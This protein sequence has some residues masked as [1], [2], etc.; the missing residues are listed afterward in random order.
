ML[1]TF[2]TAWIFIRCAYYM[3]IIC[4]YTIA[5]G[6]VGRF[7]REKADAILAW[8]ANKM[9]KVLHLTVILKNP[10]QINFKDGRRYLLMSNHTSL[11]DIPI[12]YAV[13]HETIRMVAKIELT[14]IPIF[15]RA[16]KMGEVPIVDR[17]NRKAAIESLNETQKLL[18]SGVIIWIAP[19]GTRSKTGKLLPFKKGGFIM[20]IQAQ[21]FIVPIV[22]EGAHKI[23][24]KHTW[25]FNTHGQ[26]T[27]N[28][29]RPIDASQYTLEN[30]QELIDAVRAEM[31]NFL[32]E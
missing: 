17:Y 20:G 13:L 32:E 19:E 12:T 8:W 23:L 15:G 16:L 7:T 24:P 18:N 26:V 21:A 22:I 30:K 4:L 11:F 29:C 10:H 6:S 3:A 9:L 27:V 1:T 28:L 31:L 2:K 14:R 25:Q 5:M